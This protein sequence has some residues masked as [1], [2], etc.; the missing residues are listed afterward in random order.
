MNVNKRVHKGKLFMQMKIIIIA[1][2]ATAG[3]N[4]TLDV[5][6]DFQE[7]LTKNQF[8]YITSLKT[9]RPDIWGK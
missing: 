2:Y 7:R 6:L 3:S 1:G 4:K 9:S 8:L 5:L